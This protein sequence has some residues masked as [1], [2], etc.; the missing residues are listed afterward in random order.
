MGPTKCRT[1]AWATPRAW[2]LWNVA[3][4][5]RGSC[6][7]LQIVSISATFSAVKAQLFFKS[8]L[9][10]NPA[11]STSWIAVYVALIIRL[12]SEINIIVCCS[13]DV[14]YLV[15]LCKCDNFAWTKHAQLKCNKEFKQ[16]LCCVWYLA[17]GLSRAVNIVRRCYLL[18]MKC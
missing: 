7:T 12:I 11:L 17:I 1:I 9:K 10:V 15:T 2:I 3:R 14:R 4:F 6:V 18:A 16:R 13:N 8:A 5:T